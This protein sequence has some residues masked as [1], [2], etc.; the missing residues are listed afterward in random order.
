MAQGQEPKEK[1]VYVGDSRV[2][3][4]Q[5]DNTP[6][7]Y[8]A[9]PGK[10]EAFMPNFLLKEWMVGAVVL[11]GYM[12]LVIA[13]PPPLGYPADPTNADFIPMP[14]WYFLFMY[15]LLKYPYMAGDYIVLGTL[16]IPGLAFGALLL[17]PFLDR[18]KDRRWFKRP[19]ASAL[20]L[21]SF[22]AIVYLTKVSWDHYTHEL[23]VKN[24]I[25]EHIQRA[26]LLA[27]EKKAESE[28]KIHP[29]KL[30][31]VDPDGEGFAIYSKATCLSCHAADLRGQAGSPTLRGIG[32]KYSQEE[33]MDIIVNGKGGM[34]AQF[35]PNINMG[36]T[37]AELNE[38]AGWLANQKQQQ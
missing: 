36:I 2:K 27:E 31:I 5:R 8:T 29:S 12:M 35:D 11:V 14:D 16:G 1:I 30:P 9:Y 38:L 34:S 17:A 7:D 26:A 37:E 23:E 25:P 22:V 24:Q 15:Q 21:L 32:E 13:S 4:V 28:G 3:K 10:S 18:G 6:R 33:I 19:V 20:M